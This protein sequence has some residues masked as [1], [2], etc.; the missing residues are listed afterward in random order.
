LGQRS[1]LLYDERRLAGGWRLHGAIA[2][3]ARGLVLWR[4]PAKDVGPNPAASEV[5]AHA[6]RQ[7]RTPAGRSHGAAALRFSRTWRGA[8]RVLAG[9]HGSAALARGPHDGGR[10]R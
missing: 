9:R 10:A 5:S 1:I 7:S 3:P 4:H 2:D 6:D 8:P